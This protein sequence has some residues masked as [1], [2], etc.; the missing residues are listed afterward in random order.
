VDVITYE[1]TRLVLLDY[2]EMLTTGEVS[3]IQTLRQDAITDARLLLAR[4]EQDLYNSTKK[5][6]ALDE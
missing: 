4:I 6:M 1:W 5:E 3:K 2:I